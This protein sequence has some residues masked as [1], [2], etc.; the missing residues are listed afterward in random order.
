MTGAAPA[1]ATGIGTTKPL[2][3]P[4]RPPVLLP[5]GHRVL[6]VLGS[7]TGLSWTSPDLH[8]WTA[9]STRPEGDAPG[10]F[11]A[12]WSVAVT[13]DG[14][15]LAT[16]LRGEDG[17][18]P[19]WSSTDGQHWEPAGGGPELVARWGDR[20]I[21]ARGGEQLRVYAWQPVS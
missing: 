9:S 11:A 19:T 13:R 15:V 16:D 17:G 10:R 21:G 20:V 6:D 18:V 1:S 3:Q 8:G 4:R 2:P 5:R 12:L 14:T 7:R